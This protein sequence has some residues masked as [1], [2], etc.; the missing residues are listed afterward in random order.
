MDHTNGLRD[1]RRDGKVS[2]L[3]DLLGGTQQPR[4][5]RYAKFWI[6]ALIVLV[7]LLAVSRCAGGKTGP[8]YVSEAVVQRPLEIAVKR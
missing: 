2:E 7:I 5:R 1:R 3:E 6:P 8:E 4:W